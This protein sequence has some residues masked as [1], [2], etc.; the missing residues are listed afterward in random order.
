MSTG[1]PGQQRRRQAPRATQARAS[2]ANR[3]QNVIKR[4]YADNYRCLVNFEM[5]PDA[6]TLLLGA[7]GSGKS[8]AIDALRLLQRW[9]CGWGRADVVVDADDLTAWYTGF[10]MAFEL[11]IETDGLSLEYRVE[12]ACSRELQKSRVDL[13]RLRE[14]DHTLIE[15]NRDSVQLY[16]DNGTS[17][18]S[19]PL[20]WAQSAVAAVQPSPVNTKLQA[21]RD[22]VARIIAVQ[23]IPVQFAHESRSEV[24]RP[25]PTMTDMLSWYRR[26]AANQKLVTT[27]RDYLKGVWPDFDY[28]NLVDIGRES[29]SMEFVFEP[30]ARSDPP[31]R[32]PL[33]RLSDGERMLVALYL[34]ASYQRATPGSTI[35][36]DEPDNFVSIA[37]IQPWLM[38][39]LDDRPDDGQLV[40]AS[41]SP[42]V[43]ATM[44]EQRV[45]WL[46]RENHRSPTRV[47]PLPPDQT[48]L[49]L[50]ERIARGWLDE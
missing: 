29:R 4:L 20:S 30:S 42:E 5:Q 1:D 28:I 41:H 7:N 3:E 35:W 40:I 48:G 27:F 21:F 36:L 17:G 12:F 26:L 14:G 50:S 6:E 45:A 49:P 18:G 46:T 11:G 13:E 2:P 43:V 47:R 33:E 23:P 34:L 38:Q 15:R 22:S 31:V 25:D 32:L 8:S 39:M 24:A 16:R 9:I 10:T 37:E 19:F 44:G